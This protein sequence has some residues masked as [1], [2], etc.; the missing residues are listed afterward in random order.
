MVNLFCYYHAKGNGLPLPHA[1]ALMDMGDQV[2]ADYSTDAI[3][4]AFMGHYRVGYM[5]GH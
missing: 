3:A 1:K 5:L 4:T 2:E